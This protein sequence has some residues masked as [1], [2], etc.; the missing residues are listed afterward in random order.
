MACQGHKWW[1]IDI[2]YM[3]IRLMKWVG[4][5]WDVVDYKQVSDKSK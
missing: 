4:L 3:A 5:A 1:E 2:T